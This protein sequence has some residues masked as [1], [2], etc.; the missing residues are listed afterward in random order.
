MPT[1][2]LKDGFG[3]DFSYLRISV[4]DRCNLRCNYC[5]PQSGI[6]LADPHE[7]LSYEEIIRILQVMVSLGTT[8]VRITGG[9]PLIRRNILKLIADIAAIKEITD[10]SLTTNATMLAD[11]AGS[12]KKNGLGRVNISLDSLKEERFFKLTGGGSLH[13][14]RQGI[15]AAIKAGLTPIKINV[16]VMKGVNDDELGDFLEMADELSLEVRFIEYMPII[17]SDRALNRFIASQKIFEKVKAHYRLLPLLS[18]RESGCARRYEIAGR[19]G[20]AGFISPISQPFCGSCNRMRLTANG[21]LRACLYSEDEL[22]VKEALRSDSGDLP[23]LIK[24]YVLKKKVQKPQVHEF[25]REMWGI[26][27]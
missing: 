19:R 22:N 16:V 25:K 7:I 6:Q 18:G 4:T 5:M 1:D 9:E 12:L 8:K 23:A 13:K 24:E 27:G 17:K 20:K 3:R 10:L 15:E 26:G 14:V 11:F 21:F 2:L